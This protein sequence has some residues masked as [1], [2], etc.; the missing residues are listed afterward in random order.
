MLLNRDKAY[1][2]AANSMVFYHPSTPKQ[3]TKASYV[4]YLPIT[5][6]EAATRGSYRPSSSSSSSPTSRPNTLPIL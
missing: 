4:V 3:M 6:V 2:F 1:G 5:F